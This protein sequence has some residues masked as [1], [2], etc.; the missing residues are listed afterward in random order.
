MGRH[1]RESFLGY[2]W[3]KTLK[4]RNGFKNKQESSIFLEVR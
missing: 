1:Q 4:G 3:G 2:L